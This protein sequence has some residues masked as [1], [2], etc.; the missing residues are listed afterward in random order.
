MKIWKFGNGIF[1]KIN[2]EFWKIWNFFFFENES[3]ELNLRIE[4]LENYL[5]M[6]ALTIK[7]E[8]WI[9]ENVFEDS[10]FKKL[11]NFGKCILKK[12]SLENL[13]KLFE[14]CILK[15]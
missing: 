2:L 3:F 10:I 8:N 13:E 5:R 7:F 11:W 1:L 6:E 4:I 15:N 9:L 14:N 12:S